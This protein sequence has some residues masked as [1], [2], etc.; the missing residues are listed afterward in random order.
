[1]SG[2]DP[3]TPNFHDFRD[4]S[5]EVIC[6]HERSQDGRLRERWRLLTNNRNL[7][8]KSKLRQL[9]RILTGDANGGTPDDAPG[10]SENFPPPNHCPS[11]PEPA[12]ATEE[13]T[14]YRSEPNPGTIDG[15]MHD[16][17]AKR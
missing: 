10:T 14:S 13:A 5:I 15:H 9:D 8:D 3:D 12:R 2:V 17:I 6:C 4:L 1:L 16:A 11:A 7:R